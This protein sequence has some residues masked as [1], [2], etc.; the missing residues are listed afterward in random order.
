M[1]ETSIETLKISSGTRSVLFVWVWVSLMLLR[2]G[3][4]LLAAVGAGLLSLIVCAG[5]I[6]IAQIQDRVE[7]AT[8]RGQR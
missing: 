5:F 3:D 1:R 6:S 7:D 2:F 8:E 4:K